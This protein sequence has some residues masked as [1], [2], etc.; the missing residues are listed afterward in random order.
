MLTLNQRRLDFNNV[1]IYI[2][3]VHSNIITMKQVHKLHVK[4]ANRNNIKVWKYIFKINQ[5][6]KVKLE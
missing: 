6:K 2:K 5:V 4:I 1:N 3:N